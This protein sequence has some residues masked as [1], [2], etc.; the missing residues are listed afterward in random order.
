MTNN[1]ILIIMPYSIDQKSL[2]MIYLVSGKRAS[3]KDTFCSIFSKNIA[4][5]SVGVIALA[6]APKKSFC[7]I[8]NIDYV[9]FMTDRDFKDMYRKKFIDFAEDA[10]RSDKYIWCKKAMKDSENFDHVVVSDLR[11]P[12]E[13][14]FFKKY[15]SDK[16]VTIRIEASEEIR[17]SRGWKYFADVD[18]HVS[19]T[20]MDDID[21]DFVVKNNDNDDGEGILKQ[22]KDLEIL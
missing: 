1:T 2:K 6:D 15:F 5:G 17:I 14:Y 21:F 10:K 7:E 20:G 9:R 18:N 8:E 16:F 13:L 3:G 12:I 22:I 11:Y 4:K 19:E